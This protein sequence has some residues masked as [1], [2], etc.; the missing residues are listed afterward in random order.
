MLEFEG[1]NWAN[2]VS[3]LVIYPAPNRRQLGKQYLANL[4]RAAPVLLRQLLQARA[5]GRHG[6][7]ARARFPPLSPTAAEQAQGYALFARDWMEDVPVNAV[8][9]REEVGQPLDVFAGAGEQEPL[10]FSLYPPARPGRG[11]PSPFPI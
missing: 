8:P 10:V 3:A 9:R 1:E 5:A 4:Q 6:A 2:Y 7:T 11:R